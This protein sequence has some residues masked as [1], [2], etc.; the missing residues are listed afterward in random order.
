MRVRKVEVDWGNGKA[1]LDCRNEGGRVL[2]IVGI[3]GPNASGKT[4]LLK[5]VYRSIS[6]SVASAGRDMVFFDWDNVKATVELDLGSTIATCIIEAGK[7]KQ[8]LV[9]VDIKVDYPNMT[10]G[11]MLYEYGMRAYIAH[12]N[13]T[14]LSFAE[15]VMKPILSDLYKGKVRNSVIWVDDFS[16]GLD[17]SVAREFLQVLTKKS[18]EGDN[19]LIVSTERESLLVG[20]GPENLRSLRNS[21][22]NLVSTVLKNL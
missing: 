4:M 15:S 14:K 19:Q 10:D 7:V 2:P 11:A 1:I 22:T 8:R 9:G 3:N 16:R 5:A 18:M 21:G 6:A 20:M 13:V 12:I 17:D